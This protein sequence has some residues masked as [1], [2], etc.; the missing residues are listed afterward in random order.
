MTNL[1]KEP[2]V[3]FA[4]LSCFVFF[5]FQALD[6]REKSAATTI[7]LSQEEIDRWSTLYTV[8]TGAPPSDEILRLLVADQ[9]EQK[10]L[11]REARKLGLDKTDIL[12]ERRL[13]QLARVLVLDKTQTYDPSE[14]ELQIWY[15]KHRERFIKPR[16]VSFQH[17]YFSKSDRDR[18]AVVTEELLAKPMMDWRS[19]GDPFMLQQAY[20]QLPDREIVRIFGSSFARSF[21]ALDQDTSEWQGPIESSFGMHLV[22]ILNYQNARSPTFTDIRSDALRA[23]REEAQRQQTAQAIKAVVDKYNVVIEGGDNQ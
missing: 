16:K 12:I 10:A 21:A 11:A 2:L 19:K 8:E 17:I 5:A 13:A 1:Q 23:W 7:H 6:T 9:V 15:Q 3:H 14:E 4:A 22:R 18:I 20:D